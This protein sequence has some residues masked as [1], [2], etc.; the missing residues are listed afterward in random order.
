MLILILIYYS[1]FDKIKKA[2]HKLEM[3][4]NTKN[5]DFNDK[6]QVRTN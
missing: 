6:I 4:Q 5:G 3:P 1:F 2:G